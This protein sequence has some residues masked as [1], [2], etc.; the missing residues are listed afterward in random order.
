MADEILIDWN[1]FSEAVPRIEATTTDPFGGATM[2]LSPDTNRWVWKS[3]LSGYR[4]P[5]IEEILV[6]KRPLPAVSIV[7]FVVAAGLYIGGR[8][9]KKLLVAKPVLVVMAL[10]GFGLYPF[11]GFPV[12]FPWLTR[13]TPSVDRSTI[14]LEGLLTNVYRAFDARDEN[15][16]Y[17]RLAM[18]VAGGQL[19]QIYLQNRR[20]LELE[21]RGGARA[22]VD[23]VEILSIESVKRSKDMGFVA[24]TVWTV[25]GS[26]SHYGHT[27]YRR[28]K[29][30][31]IVTFV[32]DGNLWKIRGIELIEEKRLL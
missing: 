3:R 24:D 20:S 29:N 2:I 12:E 22:N 17:D 16:V 9:H 28:N 19:A 30:H 25:S 14:I 15:R 10:L 13:W 5:V 4:V 7:L 11:V 18:S 23:K 8:H 21:N 6:E 31:A 27:H 26:V 32:V 1:L